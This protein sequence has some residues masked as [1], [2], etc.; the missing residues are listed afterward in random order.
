MNLS[1]DGKQSIKYIKPTANSLCSL[2]SVVATNIKVIFRSVE[3]LVLGQNRMCWNSLNDATCYYSHGSSLS[4][5]FALTAEL[6][7]F[8]CW[9]SLCIELMISNIFHFQQLFVFNYNFGYNYLVQHA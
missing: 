7:L 9:C 1:K 3:K 2:K 6:T 4:D 5:L 8:D